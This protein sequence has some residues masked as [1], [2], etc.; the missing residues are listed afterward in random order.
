MEEIRVGN[1][2]E[3]PKCNEC[4]TVMVGYYPEKLRVGKRW[5]PLIYVCPKCGVWMETSGAILG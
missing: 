3:K 5:M 2:F 4:G 1:A